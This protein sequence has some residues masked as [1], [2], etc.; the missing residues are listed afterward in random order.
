MK[1]SVSQKHNIKDCHLSS[2]ISNAMN[3]EENF[4]E[5]IKAIYLHFNSSIGIRFFLLVRDISSAPMHEVR[6]VDLWDELG[7]P[8]N[9]S[10]FLERIRPWLSNYLNHN[11]QSSN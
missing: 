11:N 8:L 1:L 6:L 5:A 10:D 2:L 7:G 3:D 4:L 9:K